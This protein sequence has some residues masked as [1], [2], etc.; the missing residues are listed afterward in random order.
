MSVST[1]Q[2][3]LTYSHRLAVRS[4]P[5]TYTMCNA[6]TRLKCF[7][8]KSRAIKLSLPN[9]HATTTASCNAEAW[10]SSSIVSKTADNYT[11]FALR[12]VFAALPARSFAAW[13]PA[14][15]LVP[16]PASLPRLLL[17]IRAIARKFTPVF[18]VRSAIFPLSITVN[19]VQL[20]PVSHPP[21]RQYVSHAFH[22]AP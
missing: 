2:R 21:S 17:K 14:R 9:E 3:S 11:L 1:P 20:F 10:R 16:R 12:F 6:S 19:P 22:T 13:L 5:C 4:S 15:G 7:V 8:H 18:S